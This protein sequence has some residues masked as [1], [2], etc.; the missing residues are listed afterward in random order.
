MDGR[1]LSEAQEIAGAFQPVDAAHQKP[2]G[3][4]YD[5]I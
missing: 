3:Q 1:T 4:V 5:W 2:A